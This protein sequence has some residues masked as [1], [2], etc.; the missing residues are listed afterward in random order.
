MSGE[1]ARIEVQE[2]R[3]MT[4]PE[5]KEQMRVLDELLKHVM[6]K[7]VHYG[8]IPGTK[9]PTLY[10]P[11]A[12]KI[13]ASFRL[14]PRSIVEDLS[15]PDF[16]R[17]RVRVEL[18][19]REGVPLGEGIGECSTLEEKYMWRAA[20]CEEE[21]AATGEDRK[22]VKYAKGQGGSHYTVKQIRTNAADI[23]NTV[24][25]MADKRAYIAVVLKVTAASDVF[26][27]DL[28]DLPAEVRDGI[29]GDG[30]EPLKAPQE[31]KP[32]PEKPESE[33]RAELHSMC[34]VIGNVSGLKPEEILY[35]LTV[36]K[37]GK[38][39]ESD[40]AAIK[41]TTPK[42]GGGEWSPLKA[43]HSK[44]KEQFDKATKETAA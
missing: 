16:F 12:E 36:N 18:T 8:T 21:F 31:K 34:E 11:G 3:P 25:K 35:S 37:E 42:K 30:K 22:R 10:K 41:F 9:K 17:Y 33:L 7:D 38:Y 20:V 44:A 13:T 15:G 24:L 26:D 14:V 19:N 32:E 40:F 29:V 27:Q 28:E 6:K 5:M 39:G 2:S 23:A 43:V 1:I 4:L